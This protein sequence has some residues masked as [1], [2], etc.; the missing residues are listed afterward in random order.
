VGLSGVAALVLF[1]IAG[2]L[3]KMM[4]GIR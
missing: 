2:R 4:H 3:V 1:A